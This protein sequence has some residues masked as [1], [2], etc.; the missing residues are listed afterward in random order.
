MSLLHPCRTTTPIRRALAADS[1]I[2]DSIDDRISLFFFIHFILQF[3]LGDLHALFFL[4]WLVVDRHLP[5]PSFLLPSKR[6][7]QEA[8]QY[9]MRLPD[10]GFIL[11]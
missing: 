11:C 2:D 9:I 5:V 1:A 7:A 6:F 3:V 4:L 10:H 8:L